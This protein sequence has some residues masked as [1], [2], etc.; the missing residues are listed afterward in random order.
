MNTSSYSYKYHG[1]FVSQKAIE[2]KNNLSFLIEKGNNNLM[3]DFSQVQDVD[4]VGVNTLAIIYKQLRNESG[5][6]TIELKK[7]SQLAKMLHL[8]KFEKI[9]KLIYS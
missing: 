4:V 2:L 7:N 9:F 3:L 8:T 1:D 5:S 6:M